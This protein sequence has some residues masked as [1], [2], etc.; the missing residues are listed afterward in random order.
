MNIFEFAQA[1]SA[2]AGITMIM[3]GSSWL[4]QILKA[5]CCV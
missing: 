3:I 1:M 2:L 4:K 5:N